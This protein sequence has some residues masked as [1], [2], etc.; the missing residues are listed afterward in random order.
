[1]P[2]IKSQKWKTT[3]LISEGETQR[4][5]RSCGIKMGVAEPR[6]KSHLNRKQLPEMGESFHLRYFLET[7]ETLTQ[8]QNF[9]Q[10]MIWSSEIRDSGR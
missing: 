8:R 1:M 7:L 4:L 10:D 2:E 3:S 6:D 5:G 9:Y